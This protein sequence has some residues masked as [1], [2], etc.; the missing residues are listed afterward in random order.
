MELRVFIGYDSKE[1]VA[2]HVLVHSI[3]KHAKKP[4]TIIPLCLDQLRHV[5]TRENV[6][7]TEFSLTRFLVPYLSN[8]E[9]ISVFMDCDMLVKCDL[10]EQVAKIIHHGDGK[11]VYCVKH[12]YTPK[13]LNKATG[14]QIN[15]PRK[16]W[17]SFMVFKNK[18]L[19][20]LDPNY[21]DNASAQDLHRMNWLSDNQIGDLPLDFNWLVGEYEPNNEAR[22]LHYTLGTPCFKDYQECDH[23]QEWHETYKNMISPI[24]VK[25]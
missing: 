8:Y 5:F 24:S 15:Y 1:V 18:H 7:T 21:I 25:F 16:N 11:I 3:L 9:G 2:Y 4:I 22:I 12:D 20:H 19:H 23:S 10:A 14:I 17:S 6:G 13:T